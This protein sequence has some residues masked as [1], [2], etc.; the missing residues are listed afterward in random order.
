M[1]ITVSESSRGAAGRP[2]A[3]LSAK[4]FLYMRMTACLLLSISL[5]LSARTTGQTISYSG[6]NVPLTKVF[7]AIKHQTGYFVV[8]NA[9]VLEKSTPVTV[10][11]KNTP[12]EVFLQRILSDQP[13]E[14][15]IERST[16]II[17]EKSL[18]PPIAIAALPDAPPTID[19]QG[20]VYDS[21]GRAL[22]GVSVVVKGSKHGTQ[23][24]EGG[25]FKLHNLIGNEI[26]VFL[27][28]L[29]GLAPSKRRR[30]WRSGSVSREMMRPCDLY[31][32]MHGSGMCRGKTLLPWQVRLWI[33]C[34]RGCS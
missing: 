27:P 1:Q 34:G 15:S 26:L 8:Y 25:H 29:K 16:I 6:V 2:A 33:G 30:N 11:V 10:D 21:L 12:L 19:I 24:D 14:F 9:D 32:K 23:T 4:I 20:Y 22:N 28:F 18:A 5:H 3:G 17:S 31:W 7:D 13:L